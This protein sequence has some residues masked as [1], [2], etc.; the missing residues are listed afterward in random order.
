MIANARQQKELSLALENIEAAL[1]EKSEEIVSEHLRAANRS[2]A[3]IMGSID[4]EEVLGNIFSSFC[5]GK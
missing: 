2:L 5:I 3:R 1:K 4:I